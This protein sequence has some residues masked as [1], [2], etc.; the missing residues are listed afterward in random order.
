MA[1]DTSVRCTPGYRVVV[2][3]GVVGWTVTVCEYSGGDGWWWM[4]MV[5]VWWW[6][7]RE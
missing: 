3:V 4:R 5:T 1:P 2:G 7:G 6:Q